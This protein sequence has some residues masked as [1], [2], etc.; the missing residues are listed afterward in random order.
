MGRSPDVAEAAT[1]LCEDWLN[2]LGGLEGVA[3]AGATA[4]PSAS[5]GSEDVGTP[6]GAVA[7]VTEQVQRVARA[8]IDPLAAAAPLGA[9]RGIIT[10]PNLGGLQ[11][12]GVNRGNVFRPGCAHL[13][14]FVLLSLV[15]V[16]VTGWVCDAV[17][18]RNA[19]SMFCQ[20]LLALVGWV[21]HSANGGGA[22]I[23][24]LSRD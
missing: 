11:G 17:V 24:E 23:V 14:C 5:P 7:D 2:L 19:S 15:C 3:A 12:P 16:G 22:C 21:V 18:L 9:P 4:V 1:L 13:D 8:V 10:L 20:R 6:R